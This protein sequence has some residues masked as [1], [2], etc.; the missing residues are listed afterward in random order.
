MQVEVATIGLV[1]AN[2]DGS[3]PGANG[4]VLKISGQYKIA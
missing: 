1:I 3:Y 2:Y 4:A